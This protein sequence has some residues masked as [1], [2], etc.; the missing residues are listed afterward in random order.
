LPDNSALYYNEDYKGFV[1]NQRGSLNSLAEA[2]VDRGDSARAKEVVM[3][4]LNKM[5]D[6]AVPYD[7]TAVSQVELLLQ[8]KR[9]SLSSQS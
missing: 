1:Q 6:A 7:L 4:S 5:P 3:F 2:M 9:V 8:M